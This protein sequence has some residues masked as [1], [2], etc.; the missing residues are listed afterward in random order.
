MRD[1]KYQVD[2]IANYVIKYSNKHNLDVSN[3]RLQNILYFIQAQ[4]LVNHD[5]PC[6]DARIE[7]WSFGP[8]VPIIYDEYNF[9]GS[10]NINIVNKNVNEIIDNADKTLRDSVVEHCS[11]FSNTRLTQIT[12]RQVPWTNAFEMGKENEIKLTD[13]QEYFTEDDQAI[14]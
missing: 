7:A 11:L 3:L 14:I 2:T 4:F 6:F 13:L 1:A 10:T 12:R 5:R 8:V 9:F